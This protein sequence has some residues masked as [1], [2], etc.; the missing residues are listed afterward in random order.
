L[1][2]CL[3]SMTKPASSSLFVPE[4]DISVARKKVHDVMDFDGVV[5]KDKV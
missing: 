5:Y 1:I 4:S 3:F 2:D